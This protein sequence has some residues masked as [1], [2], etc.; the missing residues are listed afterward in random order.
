MKQLIE[1]P[2]LISIDLDKKIKEITFLFNLY[3]KINQKEVME[4]F[5]SFP[6]LFC[7]DIDKIQK[8]MAEFRKYR[9][10]KE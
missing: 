5:N 7:C 6:Y 8:F 4:I 10:T 9:F 3:H 1:C 2:K